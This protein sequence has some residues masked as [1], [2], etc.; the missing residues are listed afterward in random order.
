MHKTCTRCKTFK[1]INEFSADK[2]H[3]DGYRTICKTCISK[4]MSDYMT[5]NA[6]TISVKRKT[7]YQKNRKRELQKNKENRKQNGWRWNITRREKH[8]Q[9]PLV[10]M[11]RQAKTRARKRGLEFNISP[12]KLSIP[13]ICPVLGIPLFVSSGSACYNSPTLDRIDNSKGYIDGNVVIVSFKA[14]TIK[15][16][17]S[18]EELKKV[19]TFYKGIN[20]G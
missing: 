19:F 13:S 6:N 16:A 1:P 2:T 8:K 15:N 12:E 11:C 10:M 7:R 17:A 3:S 20:N 18:V 14:N 4:Y 5:K 9:N